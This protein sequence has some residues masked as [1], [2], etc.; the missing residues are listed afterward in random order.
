[1]CEVK[2]LVSNFTLKYSMHTCL[3]FLNLKWIFISLFS[4]I[5]P[6]P[7]QEQRGLTPLGAYCSH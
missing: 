6:E 2:I 5:L 1:M 4:K 3:F 7:N